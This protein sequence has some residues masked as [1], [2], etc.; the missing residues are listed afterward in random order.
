MKDGSKYERSWRHARRLEPLDEEE[1]LSD[2]IFSVSSWAG[3]WTTAN[4]RQVPEVGRR[5]G[6]E[7]RQE[8]RQGQVRQGQVQ[9]VGGT[10]SRSHSFDAVARRLLPATEAAERIGR[11]GGGG[12]FQASLS[13]RAWRDRRS[14]CSVGAFGVGAALGVSTGLVAGAATALGKAGATVTT[15]LAAGAEAGANVPRVSL[16]RR[17]LRNRGAT[18][19][20]LER[21]RPSDSAPG[22]VRLPRPLVTRNATM[23]TTAIAATALAIF[24]PLPAAS[25]WWLSHHFERPSGESVQ[26]EPP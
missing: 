15:P 17:S 18:A 20:L 24:R 26:A 8:G 4:R 9:V 21:P 16:G 22:C 2:E 19:R 7:G 23:P 11:R 6:Q 3:D 1:R 25:A 5:Q 12:K 13:V 14:P 10:A